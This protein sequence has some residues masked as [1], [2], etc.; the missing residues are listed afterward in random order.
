MGI[1]RGR[2]AGGRT[3]LSTWLWG[4]DTPC[5]EKGGRPHPQGAPLCLELAPLGSRHGQMSQRTPDRDSANH[6]LLSLPNLHGPAVPQRRGRPR[7][8]FQ[9][10]WASQ[11]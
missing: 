7:P 1:G 3:P 8:C 9:E 5:V 2:G 4:E 10:K 6:P 11:Q